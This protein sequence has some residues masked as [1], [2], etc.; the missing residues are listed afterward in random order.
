MRAN[1][2]LGFIAQDVEAD[3]KQEEPVPA[4]ESPEE[5]APAMPATDEVKKPRK[6]IKG[7]HRE[8]GGVK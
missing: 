8:S 5:G 1:G 3:V 6:L 4:S 7:E 2:V